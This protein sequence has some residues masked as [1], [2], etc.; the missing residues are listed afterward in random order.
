MVVRGDEQRDLVERDRGVGPAHELA[1]TLG[2]L[3]AATVL[4]AGA[5]GPRDGGPATPTLG[6]RDG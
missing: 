5:A 1:E 4:D 2:H 3:H 6:R